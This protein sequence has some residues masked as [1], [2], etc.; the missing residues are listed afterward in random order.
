MADSVWFLA[1]Y[2]FYF[3]VFLNYMRDYS[4]LEEETESQGSQGTFEFTPPVSC[5]VL[6]KTH[7]YL[8]HHF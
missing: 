4:L 2:T 5:R 6:M 3:L 1:L 8:A 7:A